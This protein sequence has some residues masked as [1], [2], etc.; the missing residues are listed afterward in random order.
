M[1]NM[2]KKISVWNKEEVKEFS[3]FGFTLICD[4]VS[5]YFG[6]S[7]NQICK[8]DWFIALEYKQ[9][10]CLGICYC[11]YEILYLQRA[12]LLENSGSELSLPLPKIP[13]KKKHCKDFVG[14]MRN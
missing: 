5:K 1:L 2:Q 3:I 8:Q 4:F 12:C 9:M 13:K 10:S 7:S 14:E 11:Q 6:K